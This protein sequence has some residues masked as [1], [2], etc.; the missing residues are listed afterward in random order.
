MIAPFGTGAMQ[1]YLRLTR[2]AGSGFTLADLGAKLKLDLDASVGV[3]SDAGSTLA[4]N[5]DLAY[6]WNDQSGNGSNVLQT[7]S[8]DR[9]T[10]KTNIIDGLPIVR[11]VNAVTTMKMVSAA[12]GA[13]ISQPVT[14]FAVIIPTVAGAGAGNNQY[15]TGL[16]A[17]NRNVMFVFS[18]NHTLYAGSI[19]SGPAATASPTIVSAIFDGGSSAVRVN[20]GSD[21]TGSAG[22]LTLGG[23]SIGN[24]AAG[25]FGFDGDI[26]RIV[27]YTGNDATDRANVEAL[28]RARYPSTY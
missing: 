21:T 10:F 24:D 13:N 2:G 27:A 23:Y 17:G 18:G 26:A 4:V 12:L 14:I 5:N 22:T 9:P 28:L 15:F 19:L 20:N 8:G 3:F 16:D 1:A 11:F 6:Q 7:T 25:S